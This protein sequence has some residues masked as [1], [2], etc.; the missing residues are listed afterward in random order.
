M[1]SV[2]TAFEAHVASVRKLMH[3]DRD[4][5]KL[6]IEHIRSLRDTLKR[7]HALDNP[8]LTADNTLQML[9]GFHKHDSLRHRYQTI[10]NQAL[11]LLVSY[12]GSTVHDLFRSG[13]LRALDLPGDSQLLREQ[14]TVTTRDLREVDFHARDLV[15]DLLVQAKDISFQDMQS[16]ARAFRSYLEVQI[17]R[18]ATV[19]DIIA[20][21][22]CRH[23]VVH[24]G[25]TA[26]DRLVDCNN[27]FRS[28]P[29]PGP[30][31]QRERACALHFIVTVH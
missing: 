11:V 8:H 27:R 1:A 4:V 13:I 12:F 16:I 31:A 18:D 30:I 24:S 3:F 14:L 2:V 15:P 17:D 29:H 6:A 19:N 9:E 21:Q 26:D 22:A 7:H 5:L 23:V 10:F 20:G 25:G 28:T